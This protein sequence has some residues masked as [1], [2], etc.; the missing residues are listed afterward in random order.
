MAHGD[1]DQ[2]VLLELGGEIQ[3]GPLYIDA[4]FLFME[5]LTRGGGR[6]AV[7]IPGGVLVLSAGPSS[8]FRPLPPDTVGARVC[9]TTD[10]PKSRPSPPGGS[11]R[12]CQAELGGCGAGPSA[13][14]PDGAE[15]R[16][17]V[18]GGVPAA[19]H[20]L[21]P[22]LRLR[23]RH[24]QRRRRA[25]RGRC[26]AGLPRVSLFCEARLFSMTD[27]HHLVKSPLTTQIHI[28]P[29]MEVFDKHFMQKTHTQATSGM[30]V[31]GPVWQATLFQQVKTS[32]TK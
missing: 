1:M 24:Q 17:D 2:A 32:F 3:P 7:G 18:D 25:D 6:G 16:V 26:I 13:A 10:H 30:F 4:R 22:L 31:S 19:H 9:D 15:L 5:G 28:R 12:G 27:M 8:I 14:G 21:H 29:R 11:S 20:L 23:H